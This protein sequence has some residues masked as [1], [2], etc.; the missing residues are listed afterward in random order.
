[1]ASG[2]EGQRRGLKRARSPV[3][4]G[5]DGKTTLKD[6]PKAFVKEG[7]SDESLRSPVAPGTDGMTTIRNPPKVFVK[8]GVSDE[9]NARKERVFQKF[10]S[11]EQNLTDP[12]SL[13]VAAGTDGG[14]KGDVR[15]QN[16]LEEASK[17]G[18]SN[19][20]GSDE[21]QSSPSP[22]QI[23]ESQ[24]L[25][26]KLRISDSSS[27][28]SNEDIA[29]QEEGREPRPQSL[30][31]GTS[32]P[33]VSFI[34]KWKQKLPGMP[35][36]KGLPQ[37][38]LDR[39]LPQ[40]WEQ[41]IDRV[42]GEG[43][44]ILCLYAGKDDSSSTR[45]AF[46]TVAPH[47][48]E[49]VLELDTERCLPYHDVLEDRNFQE[50]LM[51]AAEGDLVGIL[52]GP[53]CR[54]W[55]ILRHFPKDNFPDPV[56]M[57]QGL[58]VWGKEGLA[59]EEQE[60]TDNDSLLLLRML[61]LHMVAC[62][63]LEGTKLKKEPFFL[64]EHPADPAIYSSSEKGPICSSWWVTP[65]ARAFIQEYGLITVT[66]DQCRFGHVAEKTTTI[67]TNLDLR[68][69]ANKFC[70]HGPHP[71]VRNSRSLSRWAW[72]FNLALVQA[73]LVFISQ[74]NQV[75][76]DRCVA[77]D[78]E[79]AQTIGVE[80]VQLGHK[81]RPLRDGGGKTSNGRF[82]PGDR[83]APK[84]REICKILES[85]A[86]DPVDPS[87]PEGPSVLEQIQKSIGTGNKSCPI[88]AATLGKARYMVAAQL[89]TWS[90]GVKQIHRDFLNWSKRHEGQPFYLHLLHMLAVHCEDLDADY[91]LQL[92]E[93]VNLGVDAPLLPDPGVWPT[94][95]ELGE[96]PK[97]LDPCPPQ[98]EVNYPSAAK[99]EDNIEATFKEEKDLG[100]VQGPFTP[101]QAAEFCGCDISELIIGALAAIDEGDKIR[102]IFDASI[103]WVNDWIRLNSF[104]KTTAPGLHDLLWA[105]MRCQQRGPSV[106]SGTDRGSPKA[107]RYTLF[108]SDISKAH[109][110]IKIRKADWKYMIAEIKGQLWVNMVGTYGVASAQYYWGR[111]ASLIT[112]LLYNLSEHLL[113]IL[114]FVDDY[115]V[116]TR[117]GKGAMMSTVFLL[118]M[119][120]I[121]C[122]ISWHKNALS[123]DN[124]W[125]G[126]AVD[127]NANTAWL[128]DSKKEDFGIILDEIMKGNTMTVKNVDSALGK[129]QWA[130][131]AF[132]WATPF[133]TPMYAWAKAIQS[134]TSA[135]PGKLVRYLASMVS[136]LIQG[137]P[138]PIFLPHS[139]EVAYGAS[140]AGASDT[141]A[142][143]GGWFSD[144]PNP[145]QQDVWW[146]VYELD[147]DKAPWA[148]NK[149]SPKRKIAA[150]ELLGSVILARLMS[151][152]FGT[153]AAE[154]TLTMKTDNQGNAY[155]WAKRSARKW[156]N[157]AL[158]M[159]LSA[160][161]LMAGVRTSMAHVKRDQN[162]WADDL[163]NLKL[164]GFNPDKQMFK[165]FSSLPKWL[166]FGDLLRLEAQM[167]EEN[168]A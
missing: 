98:A 114:V 115:I 104:H 74:G 119:G 163:T 85:V 95:E 96:M 25:A 54:T 160:I 20:K 87:K 156:P 136:S 47:L 145:V 13:P 166:V 161:Q 88:P 5:T 135:K 23:S 71:R 51:K 19:P 39:L 45:S 4:S 142:C 10:V 78:H 128:P 2:T 152:K 126:Y 77:M 14:E 73:A 108:K 82:A 151:L 55:S 24:K 150:L 40:T 75:A 57:R 162:I 117:E 37:R 65:Q 168:K 133:L 155:A 120:V 68:H 165:D 27:E 59:T 113:W 159:E 105:R 149:I 72:G 42:Y 100:M 91:P 97:D 106:A 124:L 92:Q 122:P 164:Q 140:D 26:Q 21:G 148:F 138:K 64:M 30:W 79:P 66:F 1:M 125:V 53:N 137:T 129:F 36:F 62:D 112:R 15:G 76:P 84:L 16:Y 110:R 50:L 9:K 46:Q 116:L 32:K 130:C 61:L 6:T 29:E 144:Q 7:V 41:N 56:R 8:E 143:I 107:A 141:R 90:P 12:A 63:K 67:M 35:G 31:T 153:R 158:M 154:V 81:S 3:A 83:P 157:C 52:G 34:D 80:K 94:K 93:G 11:E 102:T 111:M 132:P 60:D 139:V 86:L 48:W 121:G 123:A 118:F 109:R 99:F 44:T 17:A 131:K 146:F 89:L 43:P 101:A 22:V 18:S 134:R 33:R 58:G 147:S 69:M 167:D 70:N 28:S 38:L 103:T 49:D 127:I